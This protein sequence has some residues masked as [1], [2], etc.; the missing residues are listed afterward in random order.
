MAQTELVGKRALVLGAESGAGQAISIALAEGGADVA[1]VAAKDDALSALAA[2]R[3][4]QR[5]S[6]LGQRSPS[7][8]H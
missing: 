3:L 2:K 8:C 1:V 4:G 6:A 5:I 7:H